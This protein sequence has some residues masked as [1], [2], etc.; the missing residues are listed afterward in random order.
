[1]EGKD[2]TVLPLSPLALNDTKSRKKRTPIAMKSSFT[3]ATSDS[4][5]CRL[6]ITSTLF[7][8]D[9]VNGIVEE[10]DDVIATQD[11][12]GPTLV[13]RTKK[14]KLGQV[15]DEPEGFAGESPTVNVC[16]TEENVI[17]QNK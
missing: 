4:P 1:M 6:A 2:D 3:W 16:A 17:S 9:G 14:R 11:A 12:E 5:P 7:D 15:G 10:L 13:M 8:E